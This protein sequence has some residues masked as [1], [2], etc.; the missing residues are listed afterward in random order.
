MKSPLLR[1]IN[2]FV[3]SIRPKTT[4]LG[5]ISV[6]IGGLVAGASYTSINL[7][8]AVIATFFI[9]AAS[10]TYNDYFD[11]QIDKIN[12]PQRPLPQGI[13]TPKEML[14]FSIFLFA[15][16]GII[17]FFI[18]I[19]SFILIL[20]SILLLNLYELYSKNIGIFSNITVAFIS[21]MSFTFGGIAVN[22]PSPTLILSVMTFF[23][24]IGREIIMDIR[25]TEGDKTIRRSLPVQIGK[26]NASYIACLFLLISITLTPLPYLVNTLNIWY[27]FIILPVGILTMI[28]VVQTLRDVNNAAFSASLIRIALAIALI[29]FIV[30]IIV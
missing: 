2:A 1:K 17:A 10:M 22:N 23:V 21:A 13:I 14:Y 27:L 11:W 6:Y 28:G 26:K 15:I 29:A 4:P 5:M 12:H 8:L 24:M 20:L 3:V 30:G 19:L 25:D 18:N 7:L 16:G 9:T